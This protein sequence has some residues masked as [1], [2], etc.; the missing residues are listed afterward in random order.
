MSIRA[1]SEERVFDFHQRLRSNMI[2][3]TTKK[4]KLCVIEKWKREVESRMNKEKEQE[5]QM[6]KE[7]LDEE[8]GSSFRN[9]PR[10]P[11]NV[12]NLPLS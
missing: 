9:T 11:A 1:F 7:Y 2:Y 4:V 5:K 8:D 6:K 10:W 12:P 3:P